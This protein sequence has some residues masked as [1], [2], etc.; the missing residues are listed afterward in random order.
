M[1]ASQLSHIPSNILRRS[2]RSCHITRSFAGLGTQQETKI[3]P[4]V[5]R[6]TELVI[7]SGKGSEV[8][9]NEGKRYLD[10]TSGI[11]VLST[12]HCHPT[13]VKAVQEQATKSSHVQQSCYYSDV[14]NNLIE[15]LGPVVPAG[16]DSFFFSNSGAE[17]VEGAMK[18]A[19]HATGRDTV[20]S[21]LG[22]YHGRT[23]GC[24]SVTTSSSSYRGARG[25]PLPAGSVY[26][27]YP[28][29]YAGVTSEHALESLEL[30]LLQQAKASEIAAVIIEPVLGEGGYV[31]PPQ[32][33]LKSL[34]E[35]CS[36]HDI[37][38]IADEVQ[39]GYGRTGRQWAVEHFDVN[40]DI[41]VS[42]KGIASGYPLSMVTS[43]SDLTAKQQP[44]CMGGTYGGNAVSCA[45]ALATLEVFKKEGV[46]ENAAS[47]GKQLMDGLKKIAAKK[48]SPIGDV[49]GLGLMIGVEFDPDAGKVAAKVAANC[50]DQGLLILTTGHRDTIRLIPPL[51]ITS[52]EVEEVLEV[53]E[54][55]VDAL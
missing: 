49:R 40:P 32:G 47:R 25:G 35:W 55:A 7:Q 45:A 21:F 6:A 9:T 48:G 15:K 1:A 14:V 8:W 24:L 23:A 16:H 41:L 28:Y 38:F 11:G 36:K 46:V 19:R 42:A 50:F 22:G 3:F 5:K 4:G 10:L 17:A 37:L 13:V 27:K 34:R 12:G 44:G 51:V 20:I 29:E 39:C 30:I 54:K 26:A 43:R 31:V 18:L 53:F 33:F 52:Q 2:G